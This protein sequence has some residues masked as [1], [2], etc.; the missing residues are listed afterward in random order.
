VIRAA[1]VGTGGIAGICHVP[2]LRAAADRAV[3]VAGMDVDAKSAFT[4]RPVR[5]GEIGAADPFYHS[6]NGDL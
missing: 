3:I 1:I 2:A 5:R 6:M 4:A